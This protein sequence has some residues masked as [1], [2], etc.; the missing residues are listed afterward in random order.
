[1]KLN[2]FLMNLSLPNALVKYQPLKPASCSTHHHVLLIN[3]VSMEVISHIYV[4]GPFMLDKILVHIHFTCIVLY[5]RNGIRENMK[6]FNC[7]LIHKN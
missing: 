4:F 2:L 1:M 6:I 3:I 7:C 5:K